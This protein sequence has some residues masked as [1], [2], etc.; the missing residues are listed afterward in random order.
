MT[1]GAELSAVRSIEA[2]R[3]Q[4]CGRP[5][6]VLR[7][8]NRV[9]RPRGIIGQRHRRPG[10]LMRQETGRPGREFPGMGGGGQEKEEGEA[11]HFYELSLLPIFTKFCFYD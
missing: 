1:V 4:V 3:E 5:G 9:N 10:L 7:D 8:R 11:K 2:H 6:R